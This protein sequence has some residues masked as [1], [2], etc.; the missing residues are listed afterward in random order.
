MVEVFSPLGRFRSIICTIS[1]FI[2]GID[3]DILSNIEPKSKLFSTPPPYF[4]LVGPIAIDMRLQFDHISNKIQVAV[5]YD[6]DISFPPWKYTLK[7]ADGALVASCLVTSW[8]NPLYIAEQQIVTRFLL[9]SAPT[10]I[11]YP[12]PPCFNILQH[13]ILC[14]AIHVLYSILFIKSYTDLFMNQSR[15]DNLHRAHNAVQ[16]ILYCTTLCVVLQYVLRYILHCIVCTLYC[17]TLPTETSSLPLSA[18]RRKKMTNANCTTVPSIPCSIVSIGI[19]FV[20]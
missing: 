13:D 4:M 6:E 9:S 7:V 17:A 2:I 16:Y 10:R 5:S 12:T 11:E 8:L 15:Q 20:S 19:R 18:T 1:P 3:L 14:S